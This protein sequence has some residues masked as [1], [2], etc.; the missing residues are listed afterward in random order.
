M[1]GPTFFKLV[2]PEE[3]DQIL[4]EIT[5]LLEADYRDDDGNWYADY[6]RLRFIAIK[7]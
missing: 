3:T 6:K 1:F 4:E 7:E 5:A 2:K